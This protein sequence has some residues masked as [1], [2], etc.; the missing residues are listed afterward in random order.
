MNVDYS[1]CE[2]LKYKTKGFLEALLFY[3]VACEWCV[4]FRKRVQQG[5]FLEA[6]K[7]NLI[8]GI[9]KFHLNAHKAD[10]FPLFSP[11]FIRGAGQI[12][13]EQMETLWA[14]LNKASVVA[15]YMSKAHRREVL[16]DQ[17]RDSNW[18]KVVGMGECPSTLLHQA[19]WLM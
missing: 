12:D 4:N 10:C 15:K 1:I 3:D 5:Q 2:A 8:F 14:G 9:G 19:D 16:D 13:G 11:N 17:M 7:M 18:K 6:P